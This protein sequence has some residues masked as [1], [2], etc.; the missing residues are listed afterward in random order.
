MASP[1]GVVILTIWW[2]F[3]RKDG[4]DRS[5]GRYKNGEKY[6]P[7]VERQWESLFWEE[8]S[9]IT[10]T[11]FNKRL[12]W[13]KPQT[14]WLIGQLFHW[15]NKRSTHYRPK[16]LACRVAAVGGCSWVLLNMLNVGGE[17]CLFKKWEHFGLDWFLD[18]EGK[19]EGERC[20]AYITALIENTRQRIKTHLGHTGIGHHKTHDSIA[21]QAWQEGSKAIRFSYFLIDGDYNRCHVDRS[22]EVIPPARRT[23]GTVLWLVYESKLVREW[24]VQLQ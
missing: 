2:K 11:I 24:L 13:E 8:T 18:V 6:P 16:H 12:G 9:L 1:T 7:R 3:L 21:Q 4:N 14:H 5:W 19:Y 23:R 15:G 22:A 17:R 20:H 10:R